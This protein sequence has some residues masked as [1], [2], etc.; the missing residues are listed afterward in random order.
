MTAPFVAQVELDDALKRQLQR[1]AKREGLSL[2][3]LIQKVLESYA[4]LDG[5]AF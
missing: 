5:G 1:L 2:Y 4:S 3:R